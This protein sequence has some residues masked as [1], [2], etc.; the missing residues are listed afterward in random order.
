MPGKA[1]KVI[2]TEKQHAVLK[3]FAAARTSEVSLAQRSRIILLAFEGKNNEAIEQEVG[4]QHDAVGVWRR[5]WRDNWQRLIS[6]E[7]TDESHVV[8]EQEIRTLLS[9]LSRT[10]R[11]P[12]ITPEQQAAAFKKACEDPQDSD[13]PIAKWTHRE[14]S[15]QMIVDG[16]L[17]ASS[18]RWI[19]KLLRR[20]ALRP[21]RNK[22]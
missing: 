1:A 22:Y 5:R 2:V 6:I 3:K 16:V 18:G 9:D 12:T 15:C 20:A 14:L 17:D 21:H 8:L 11:K 19:G 4:L 13:R 10:G 7:C